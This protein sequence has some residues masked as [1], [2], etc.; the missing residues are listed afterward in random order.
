MSCRYILENTDHY[1]IETNNVTEE[2]ALGH[3]EWLKVSKDLQKIEALNLRA[4]DS[5]REVE[6]RFFEEGY[7]KFNVNTGIFIEKFNSG[8]HQ[9]QLKGPEIEQLLLPVLQTYFS[10]SRAILN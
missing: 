7:L 1:L 6:E 5:S 10:N 8:Q 2:D 3:S 4:I 9:Y